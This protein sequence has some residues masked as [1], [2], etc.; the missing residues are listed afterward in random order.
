MTD[1][2]A[3]IL[4]YSVPFL[5]G[6]AFAFAICVIQSFRQLDK[7][8]EKTEED[9]TTM[10]SNMEDILDKVTDDHTPDDDEPAWQEPELPFPR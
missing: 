3:T 1:L 4:V 6:M 5:F 8:L 9:L 10:V 7:A 2:I